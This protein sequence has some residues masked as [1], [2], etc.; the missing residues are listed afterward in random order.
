M[1]VLIGMIGY[2]IRSEVLRRIYLQEPRG[3]FD[4][5]TLLGDDYKANETRFEA[6]TRKYERL[7]RRMLDGD[8]THLLTVEDDML[9]PLDALDRLLGAG[10]DVAYGLYCWRYEKMHWWSAYLR[11]QDDRLEQ[12]SN[13]PLSALPDKAR[14]MWGETV[15]VQGIGLGCTLISRPVLEAI[16]FRIAPGGLGCNDLYFGLD[17]QANNF[18]QVC[19]TAVVCGHIC[20]DGRAVWPDPTTDNLIRFS[21]GYDG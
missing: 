2:T 9:I 20:E 18:T 21:E 1:R 16:P 5:L 12:P 10:A 7:R 6:V 17:C 14:A 3:S 13:V 8:Y 19:D 11:L 15:L 4:V